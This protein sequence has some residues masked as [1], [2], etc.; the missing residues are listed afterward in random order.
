MK[1]FR[2]NQ[3]DKEGLRFVNKCTLSLKTYIKNVL[4]L[5]TRRVQVVKVDWAE[6]GGRDVMWLRVGHCSRARLTLGK[7]NICREKK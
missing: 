6:L 2:R 4:Y 5:V 7:H 3:T 1:D